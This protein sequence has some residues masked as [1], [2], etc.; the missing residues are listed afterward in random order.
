MVAMNDINSFVKDP[1]RLIELCRDVIAKMDSIEVSDVRT[2]E[3]ST[4]DSQLREIAKAIE[5]LE[6]SGVPIPDAL[7][8]E[9]TR[10]VAAISIADD[11]TAA[12]KRLGD[13]LVDTV[14]DIRVRLTRRQP[15]AMQMKPSPERSSQDRLPRSVLREEIIVAL[16]MLGGSAPMRTVFEEMT[17]QLEGRFLPGDLVWYDTGKSRGLVWE[18][19]AWEE[20]ARLIESDVI[21]HDSPRGIWKLCEVGK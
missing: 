11:A 14:K 16:K 1:A 9:K 2:A 4:M 12:L 13:Q 10:L 19:A 21:C 17:H 3:S 8:S 6:K 20:R 5:R 15:Q 7:R 18:R